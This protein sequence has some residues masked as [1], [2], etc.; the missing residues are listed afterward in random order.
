MVTYVESN[1]VFNSIVVKPIA[2]QAQRP[3]EKVKSA[4]KKEV[5][6]LAQ[7]GVVLKL[8]GKPTNKMGAPPDDSAYYTH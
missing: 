8:F 2:N 4:F 5:C 1:H 6:H 3:E 7:H